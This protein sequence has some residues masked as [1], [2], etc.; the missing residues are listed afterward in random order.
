M[1]INISN[2]KNIEELKL[3]IEDNKVN[4]I[5]GISGSGKSSIA[6]ALSS[7]VTDDDVKVGK[8][9]EECIIKVDDKEVNCSN[10]SI[11][12]LESSKNMIFNNGQ[13]ENIYEILFSDNKD[14][15]ETIEDCNLLLN[16]FEDFKNILL[17]YKNKID[18]I[19][20]HF[21]VKLKLNNTSFSSTSKVVK[22]TNELS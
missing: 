3:E 18:R 1:K 16:K 6:K 15:L 12:D 7:Q 5:F 11:F 20:S 10:F 13:D 2:Y 8:K 17:E 9:I 14:L 21:D 22:L 4:H 19:I